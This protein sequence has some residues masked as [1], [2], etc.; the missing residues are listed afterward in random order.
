MNN[1]KAL[2]I[3]PKSNIKL[4]LQTIEAGHL[5][6]ALVVD[7]ELRLLGTVTD[8]DIRR[9]LIEGSSLETNITKVMSSSPH[10][11]TA[12]ISRSVVFDTLSKKKLSCMPIIDNGKIVDLIISDEKLGSIKRDNPVFLMAGGFGKRLRPLTNDCP[13]PMLKFGGK[14]ILETII[15]NFKKA[16]FHDFYIST[17]Y[18]PDVIK[19]YFEDGSKW[20]VSIKYV[21]EESP[22]GTGG[23]LSLLPKNLPDLPIIVMNADVVTNIN[24]TKLLEFYS[25]EKA[26]AVMCV[27]EYDVKIPYGVVISNKTKFLSLE[28]KPNKSFNVNAGIYVLNRKLI[29]SVRKNEVIDM[30]DLLAKN[31]ESEIMVFPVYEYWLDIGQVDDLEKAKL[32][33]A[34]LENLK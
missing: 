4:A 5:K 10:F 2:C 34:S 7:K 1:W 33:M 20:G 13:K 16:G 18:L 15:L 6:I 19:N 32:Y 21:F 11:L 28:E 3:S 30:P 22:L 8:G 29:N 9:A 12:D 23:A 17:H 25:K 26:D 14:P 27:R 31:I 24:F